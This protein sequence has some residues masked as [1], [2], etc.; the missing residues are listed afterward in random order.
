MRP[1]LQPSLS[2][3]H[4]DPLSMYVGRLSVDIP[5]ETSGFQQAGRQPHIL[6]SRP[7]GLGPIWPVR[8]DAGHKTRS[9]TK[10]ENRCMDTK[11]ERV[12]GG[13]N[14]ETGIDTY[15]LLILCINWTTN[16]NL[17]YKHRDCLLHCGDINGTEI[18]PKRGYVYMYGL[19]RWC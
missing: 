12:G 9:F 1:G 16:K 17:L 5:G 18:P 15:T 19:P 11:G 2:E 4:A 13:R 3:C 7:T 6:S 14:W 8:V 10:V